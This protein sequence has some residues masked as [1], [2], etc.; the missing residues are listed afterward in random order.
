[1]K[2]IITILFLS[3]GLTSTAFAQSLEAKPVAELLRSLQTQKFKY[4]EHA[5]VTGYYSIHSCLYVSKDFAVLKNYCY[6]AKAYPAKGFTIISAKYGIVDLYQEKLQ[7]NILKHDVLINVFPQDYADYA[8]T[9]TS[10]LKIDKI[11]TIL[12]ELYARKQGACW[13]TNYSR[14]IEA[15]DVQ[16]N[17]KANG[18]VVGYDQWAKET[19]S[20]TANL[21]D[22]NR[23]MSQVNA[24]ITR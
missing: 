18:H 10:T 8:S 13:S 7:G 21:K 6:P 4:V 5:L 23:L 3:L 15:P 19:Q 11:N 12:D 2:T 24:A 9:P 17:Q 22:W 16:C 20:L 14:Y 1:M